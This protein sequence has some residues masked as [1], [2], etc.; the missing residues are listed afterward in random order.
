MNTTNEE[1]AGLAPVN[2]FLLWQIRDHSPL[3]TNQPTF[4]QLGITRGTRCRR[5]SRDRV[6]MDNRL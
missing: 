5:Q 2:F 1:L 4:P 3:A 6:S